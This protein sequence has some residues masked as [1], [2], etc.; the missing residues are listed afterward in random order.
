VFMSGY[1]QPVLAEKGTLAEGVI[2]LE[3]PFTEASLLAKL[4]E[5][6]PIPD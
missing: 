2:L 1:A 6:A 4:T 5:G 3:K